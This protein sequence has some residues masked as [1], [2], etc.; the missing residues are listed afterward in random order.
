MQN[1]GNGNITLPSPIK[2]NYSTLPTLSA[3]QVGYTQIS[4]WGGDG[5]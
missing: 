1:D 4:T 3:G 2:I 5:H